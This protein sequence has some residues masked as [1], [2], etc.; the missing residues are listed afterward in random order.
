MAALYALRLDPEGLARVRLEWPPGRPLADLLLQSSLHVVGRT[1]ELLAVDEP[2]VEALSDQVVQISQTSRSSVWPSKRAILRSYPDRIEY[3]CEVEGSGALEEVAFFEAGERASGY[4]NRLSPASFCRPDRARDGWQGSLPYFSTVF[5]PSP[6]G[7]FR[8]YAWPGERQ[9]IHPGN[10]PTWGGDWF[11][12]PGPFVFGLGDEGRWLMAGL[13]CAAE[14]ATFSHYAYQGGPIWGLRLTYQGRTFVDGRWRTPTVVLLPVEDEYTGLERYRTWLDESRFSTPVDRGARPD[15]WREPIWCGWGE[16]VAREGPQPARELS[17]EDN[18][19]AW[20]GQL[21][22]A[23]VRP[24]TIIVDDRWMA[25]MGWPE[26]HAGRWP[27]LAEFIANRKARGQR[28]LLWHNAWELEGAATS[29][30]VARRGDAPAQGVFGAP[31][32]DPTAPGAEAHLRALLTRLLAPPPHGFGADG[33]KVDIT[34]STP[35]QRDIALHGSL[36]GNALLHRLLSTTYRLAKEIRSD[37]LIECHAANPLF[38]DTADVLRLNDM[39]TDLTSVVAMMR[40]R[41]RVAET[42]GFD[43]LDCDGWPVPSLA[44]LLEYVRVQPE[45]G[46]PALYCATRVDE[47]REALDRAALEEIAAVWQRYRDAAGL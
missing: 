1:D 42:A 38:R 4:T 21:E 44:S 16:Q 17:T 46:I 47:S 25:R 15:W 26:P 20:L 40:H 13:G 39:H 43:L 14:A 36:W 6:N 12:T 34:H 29:G 9:T 41:A 35:C 7:A 2:R 22:Q 28:V 23:G 30:L 11:F 5:N 8:Q 10:D 33:L 19:S 27:H 32:L 18:Y 45:L 31:L 3:W 37:A 24:G